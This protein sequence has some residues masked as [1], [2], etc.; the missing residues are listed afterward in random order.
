MIRDQVVLTNGL[1]NFSNTQGEA[2]DY[3]DLHDSFKVN[4]QLSSAYEISLTLT[5]TDQ[6]AEAYK[7]A[8]MKRYV[9]YA[10][11]DGTRQFFAIQQM[12]EGIDEN[13][14][15]TLQITATHAL[16]DLMKNIRIDPK[17]PT[18]DNPDV[19]GSGS[20]SSSDSSAH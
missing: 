17:Q 20:D 8:K 15:P 13:G 14:Q 2:V 16:I 19:S 18:E 9:E 6:F 3:S 10:Y 7:L 12:E 4:Y 1:D 11:D 5:Y